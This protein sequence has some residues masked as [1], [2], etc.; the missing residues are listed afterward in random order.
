VILGMAAV[1]TSAAPA[2]AFADALRGWRLRRSVSQLELALRAGTTQ[3]HVSFIERGRSMPGRGMVIRLAEALEVPLRH[4]NALLL[5]AGYAPAYAES[6]LED[7]ALDPVRAAL[8]RVLEGHLPYP[9]VITDRNADLVS[10]NAAFGA[11]VAGVA[12]SLLAAPVNVPR[13]LLDPG[14]LA[15]RIVNLAEWGRHV[16]DA[17]R[18][19][20]RRDGSPALD[21]LAAELEP[22]LPER[23][24]ELPADHLGVAVPL[25]LRAADGDGELVLLTTL[26][27]FG[28]ATDVTIAELTLEAFL[29][30]DA[31]TARRLAA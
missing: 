31:A 14:G 17:L 22:L 16:I 3:R 27:H 29:P 11:L 15:P 7:P 25:R 19:S 28:T 26:S 5:S 23:P 13:L 6:R 4:R 1:P 24:R 10:A 18:R 8:E 9:A 20:A 2:P 12:P 30:A 21:A